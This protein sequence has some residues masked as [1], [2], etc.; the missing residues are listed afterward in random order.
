M[1]RTRT[2]ICGITRIEDAL[3]AASAGADAIGLIFYAGSPRA[4]NLEQAMLKGSRR[5][6]S[7]ES[8]GTV[9]EDASHRDAV[10]D[11][12]VIGPRRAGEGDAE[13]LP[14]VVAEAS[15]DGLVQTGLERP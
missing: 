11:D 4:V 12:Q 5:V 9:A 3:C 10:R 6:G 14:A 7:V 8:H 2:K 15:R 13:R 1:T